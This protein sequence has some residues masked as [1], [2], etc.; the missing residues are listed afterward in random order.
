VKRVLFL[1]LVVLSLIGLGTAVSYQ[2]ARERHY[3][4]LLTRGD[5]ALRD[6]QTFGAIEAYSGAIALRGDSMLPYLRRGETYQRRGELEAA[7]RDFKTAVMLDPTATRPLDELGDIRYLQQ[8]FGSAGQ[9]YEQY[10]RLDDRAAHVSYKLA[11]ARYRDGNLDGALAAL[12]ATLRLSG[13]L[14]EAYY[15]RGLCLRDQHRVADAQ[16]ALARAVA[17]SPGSVPAREELADLYASLARRVDELEQLQVLA[18][19]DRDRPERQVAVGLAHARWSADPQEPASRRA[20]HADLAVLTLS[21]ALERAPDHPLVYGAL[22]RVWLDI[23][24]A[25]NDL[26]ALNKALEALELIGSTSDATSETLTLYGRALLQN[27]QVD[28]AERTLQQATERYPVEPTAFVFYAT[29][30]EQQSHWDAARQ[31]WLMYGALVGDGGDFQAR[32]ERIAA[33]SLHLD[34]T[35]TALEW[36]ERANEVSPANGRLVELLA[37]AQLRAGDRPAARATVARGL[38]K[39]PKDA[40]LLALSRRLRTRSVSE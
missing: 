25:R 22:G 7:A 33:L 18:A 39:Y 19:L 35:A 21:S 30:A 23:A 38:G 20:E 16:Q 2:V 6:A 36:L 31:A 8:R 5:I 34:D 28:L 14:A 27:G 32:A 12:D 9:I 37:D 24:Q 10:L 29:A 15:L 11:L 26:V 4:D 3:R 17:L 1:L 13:R 40:A